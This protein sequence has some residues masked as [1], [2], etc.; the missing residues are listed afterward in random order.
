MSQIKFNVRRIHANTGNNDAFATARLY[1]GK[2]SEQSRGKQPRALC[3]NC[4]EK[5]PHAGRY[6]HG[7]KAATVRGVWQRPLALRSKV[8]TTKIQLD[9]NVE[10]LLLN[11]GW[12]VPAATLT[13]PRTLSVE[14]ERIPRYTIR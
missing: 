13:L 2:T 9:I 7:A 8:V 14:S 12:T 10:K 1:F 3:I 11:R 5:K 4:D 6:P